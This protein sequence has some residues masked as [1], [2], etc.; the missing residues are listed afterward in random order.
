MLLFATLLAAAPPD[1]GAPAPDFT[2]ARLRGGKAQLSVF[3]RTSPVVLIVLRGY[4]GYQCPYCN[5]QTHDF[6]RSAVAF[7]QAGVHV[8]LVYPG[9]ARDLEKRAREFA[10]DKVF[11]DHFDLLLDPDYEFTQLYGLR[12]NQTGETAYPSTFVIDRQGKVVLARI[13]RAHEDRSTAA[14]ILQFLKNLGK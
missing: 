5:R 3:T 6:L 2:L 7:K 1:V 11:P 9:A 12:W 4:P 8:I 13:G 10:A 14:E